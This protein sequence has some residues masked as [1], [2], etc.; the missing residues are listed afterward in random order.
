MHLNVYFL[1]RQMYECQVFGQINQILPVLHQH[2]STRKNSSCQLVSQNFLQALLIHINIHLGRRNFCTINIISC[3]RQPTEILVSFPAMQKFD[4]A[5]EISGAIS[6][7]Q[8]QDG[9]QEFLCPSQQCKRSMGHRNFYVHQ[10]VNSEKFPCP[11]KQCNNSTGQQNRPSD[12][13]TQ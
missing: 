7:R 4:C 5:A 8:I 1:P 10:N 2:H 13:T 11:S 6:L 3:T 12:L 9:P